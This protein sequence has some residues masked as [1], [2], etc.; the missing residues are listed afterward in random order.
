M[1]YFSI[2][3]NVYGKVLKKYSERL[4][5]LMPYIL[6]EETFSDDREKQGSPQGDK[7]LFAYGGGILV[8]GI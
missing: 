7:G 4:A 5:R 6:H 3:L 2:M 1:A 8:D